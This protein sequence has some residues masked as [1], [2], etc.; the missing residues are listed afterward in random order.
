[1]DL[2][3]SGSGGGGEMVS[4]RAT[5]PLPQVVFLPRVVG[6]PDLGVTAFTLLTVMVWHAWETMRS[7]PF[8]R[9][10]MAVGMVRD[11][12]FPLSRHASTDLVW[13]AVD[14]LVAAG[15]LETESADG[16]SPIAAEVGP[17]FRLLPPPKSSPSRRSEIEFALTAG[18]HKEFGLVDG[19]EKFVNFPLDVL[20]LAKTIHAVR[21]CLLLLRYSGRKTHWFD[22]SPGDLCDA[23]GLPDGSSYRRNFS[24]LRRNIILPAMDALN[25]CGG[26]HAEYRPVPQ[27]RRL[28]VR[29]IHFAAIR[30]VTPRKGHTLWYEGPGFVTVTEEEAERL[31]RLDEI[32][33]RTGR[34]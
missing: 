31:C 10:R 30:R 16:T 34:G 22:I 20:P 32:D 26:V 29:M 1:M 2:K 21:L 33:D 23:V 13:K 7:D 25:E 24:L 3:R 4:R 15:F 11:Y 5:V 14:E 12:L 27:G 17:A 19:A 6:N 8:R 18:G 28:K 9:H